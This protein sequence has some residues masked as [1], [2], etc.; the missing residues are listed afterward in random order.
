MI[1]N[2]ENKSYEASLYELCSGEITRF[3]RYQRPLEWNIEQ[4]GDVTN[5]IFELAGKT[6]EYRDAHKSNLLNVCIYQ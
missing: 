4:V 1:E 3:D 6:A 5:E 2:I